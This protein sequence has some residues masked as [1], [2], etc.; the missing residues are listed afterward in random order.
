MLRTL[1][2]LFACAAC[3]AQDRDPV[4]DAVEWTVALRGRMAQMANPVVRTYGTAGL[5]RVVCPVDQAA[6][7]SL[8]RD[9]IASLFNVSSSA[10]GERGTTVLPVASYS[11]LWKSVIPAALK[12]DPGLSAIAENQRARERI[13]AE[14]AGANATLQRA[15]GLLSPNMPLDKQDML[16]RAAQV[17]R[18]D[19]AVE[20]LE[21]AV[22]LG[23]SHWRWMEND[24]DLDPLRALPRYVKLMEHLKA[25]YP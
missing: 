21:N 22:K 1:V 16:D 11:G 12:C 5:A 9:A 25:A 19:Q 6:A 24:S 20:C 14:R 13:A 7:S 4:R 15:Y 23:Y 18:A 10:F 8:Y 17:G 2:V 3:W